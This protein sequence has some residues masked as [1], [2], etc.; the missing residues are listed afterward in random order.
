M[1]SPARLDKRMECPVLDTHSLLYGCMS[2]AVV[3]LFIFI[4]LGG[5]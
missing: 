5:F 1:K 4:N 2:V 3:M